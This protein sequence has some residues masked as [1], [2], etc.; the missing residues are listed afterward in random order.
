VRVNEALV[1]TAIRH[2]VLLV[3][4]TDLKNFDPLTGELTSRL[5]GYPHTQR[6]HIPSSKRFAAWLKRSPD[7][8]DL[9]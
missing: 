8:L 7:T 3:D 9:K 2:K 1:K 5:A 4:L 6:S